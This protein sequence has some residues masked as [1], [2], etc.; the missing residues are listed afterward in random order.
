MGGLERNSL[1]LS[2]ALT[3]LGHDVYLFTETCESD[4]ADE[5]YPFDVVRS[6]SLL[7]L[8]RLLRSSDLF[9]VNGNVSL[10]TIPCA[11][12]QGIPYGIIYHSYRG[13]RRSGSGVRTQIENRLRRFVAKQAAANIFT[14]SHARDRSGLPTSRCHVV[15]NPV[16]KR[17]EPLYDGPSSASAERSPLLFAGRIIEGKGVFV[18]LKALS[19]L[20]GSMSFDMVIAGEGPAESEMRR[21]SESFE[22]I[23]V[24]FAGRLDSTELVG[25]Y[26]RAR[27]LVVP[28][29]THKEGNPLVVAEAIFAG[30]PVIASDQPPMIESVGEAG[31]IVEQGDDQA[32]AGAIRRVYN[33]DL[34]YNSLCREAQQRR[35]LFGYQQYKEEIKMVLDQ[36][37]SPSQNH[38]VPA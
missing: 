27:A 35:R 11:L 1:T 31:I 12:M 29:T 38:S 15:L 7:D 6:Q 33:D 13:Y 21:R 37:G 34:F 28:S 16:D 26:Q 18:L 5:T 4:P 3:D 20:D 30:T 10:Q 17:M 24:H 14:N 2:L 36:V 23:D 9:L 19:Y 22:T 25:A 32:L 8:Y